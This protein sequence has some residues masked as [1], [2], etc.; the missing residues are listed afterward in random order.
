M[1]DP[2]QTLLAIASIGIGATA[3]MDA[4]SLLRK[5]L[6]GVPQLDYALVGRWLLYLPRGQWT[7][8]PIGATPSLIG[9]RALGWLAHYLI[10]VGFAGVLIALAGTRWV[11]QPTLAPALMVGLVT[12][13]LPFFVLQPA[14]GAG[15]AARRTPRP[16]SARFHS[17]VTHGVFG[18]G[19]YLS[20]WLWHLLRPLG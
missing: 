11:A 8:H 17:V 13:V 3:V 6:L 15:I 10:G 18:V 14:L 9:E 16:W 19:M 2:F 4:W 1:S 7:H 12:V 20:G 5:R